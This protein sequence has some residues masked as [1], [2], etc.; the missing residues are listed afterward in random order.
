VIQPSV[1]LA[2][3][4]APYENVAIQTTLTEPTDAVNVQEGDRVTQ[5]EVLAQLDTADLQAMLAADVAAANGNQANTSH[6]IY[7]GSLTISQGVNTVRAAQ[8]ALTR[9]QDDLNRYQAL[10]GN[11]Y[12]SQQQVADQAATVRNDA[13]TLASAQQAVQA[14]GTLNSA[15][16]QQ[17]SVQQ[18]KAQEQQAL[19]Q[20]Q[21]ERVQIAKATITS[22][23][24]G[25]V[26]NRNLN[27]GEYPGT[28][29]IFTLQQIDPIYAVLHG[30]GAQI[31]NI[32]TGTRAIIS[33]GDI[34]T[35]QYVGSVIGV[36]NQIAP[37][38]TDFQVKILLQNPEQKLRPGMAV[39]GTIALPTIRGVRIPETAFTDDNHN[40]VLTVADDGTVK[41]VPVSER[42]NDG[43]ISIVSGITSG[44]RIVSDGQSSVGD[45]EKIVYQGE[46]PAEENATPAPA[47]SGAPHGRHAS[48]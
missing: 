24:N 13:A 46:S 16:L 47:S 8:A 29:Q 4:V 45:G 22:P 14:N 6:T 20:A 2:G 15:G 10:Y 34:G 31:A 17:S 26:V 44:T 48:Q 19:A 25:V 23:I 40:A 1:Q 3:I 43:T 35:A 9:D 11:G 33:S 27:P 39:Q 38:S 41:T 36:L 42:A 7:Q 37:G 18:S 12:V 5:G 21:Q 28:R 32:Q 30:S